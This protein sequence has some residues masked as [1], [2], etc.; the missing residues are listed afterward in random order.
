M[1]YEVAFSRGTPAGEYTINLHLYRNRGG[2]LP[3]PAVVVVVVKA[4]PNSAIQPIATEPAE[5]VRVGQELTVVRFSLDDSGN[6]V[7]GSI[8]HL[9]RGLR[10]A[11][12]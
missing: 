2:R 7:P 10:D 5:L 1:N 4:D 6:L 3:I 12:P 9:Q 8:H 11:Q